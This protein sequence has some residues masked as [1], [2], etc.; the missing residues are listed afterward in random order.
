MHG[1]FYFSTDSAVRRTSYFVTL[2]KHKAAGSSK[3]KK[4][5]TSVYKTAQIFN[6]KH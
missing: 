6:D 1:V 3:Y 5:N 4:N 2:T